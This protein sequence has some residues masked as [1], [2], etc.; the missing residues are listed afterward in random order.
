MEES[1]EWG[2]ESVKKEYFKVE[3]KKKYSLFQLKE[4]LTT[5]SVHLKIELLW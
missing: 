1:N 3:P 2:I 5:F 4:S